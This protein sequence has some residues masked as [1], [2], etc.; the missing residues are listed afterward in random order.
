MT[1]SQ[2]GETL[3]HFLDNG[4]LRGRWLDPK[5]RQ[6]MLISV[7]LLDRWAEETKRPAPVPIAA[8][9]RDLLIDW[10]EWLR[11]DR[12]PKTVNNK[13]GDVMTL[14]RE[15]NAQGKCGPVDTVRKLPEPRR[16]PVAWT[17]KQVEAIFDEC[18][19]MSGTWQGVPVGLAWR[20]GFLLFWDTAG[21]LNEVLLAEMKDLRTADGTLYVPAEHR[22]GKRADKIY[23]LHRQTWEA[24]L[25]SLPSDRR[26]VFPFP[27]KRGQ[28]WY[29]LK[30]IL[31]SAGL[32][33]DRA[34]MFHCFRR[35]AESY[36]ARDR[37]AQWAADAVG[38][39]LQV[40]KRHYIS[41]AIAPG[42]SLIDALPRPQ[43]GAEPAPPAA[44]GEHGFRL[45]AG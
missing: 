2:D 23:P 33:D 42:P 14:W 45:Y 22:K 40:A 1:A 34:H 44:Q 17:I 16:Q 31:R 37:G 26:L 27:W 9:S 12:S 8:L 4:Y 18:N 36:A 5:T 19:R 30:R 25:E 15:A 20:I 28:I 7:G 24:I 13:R 21:R 29:H 38:H 32:P 11:R 41:D 43:I 6:Q 3:E 39:S 10:M 35:S